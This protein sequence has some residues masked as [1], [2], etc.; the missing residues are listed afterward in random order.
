M[1]GAG[2]PPS[3][4]HRNSDIIPQRLF[5]PAVDIIK[6]LQTK[7][8]WPAYGKCF[9]LGR[10]A[11]QECGEKDKDGRAIFQAPSILW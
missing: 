4:G 10:P 7:R 3:E 8:R 2:K 1:T 11:R 9:G 5:D 6:R